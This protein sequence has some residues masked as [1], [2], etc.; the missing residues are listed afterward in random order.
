[1]HFCATNWG[2]EE[3]TDINA[4]AHLSNTTVNRSEVG[5]LDQIVRVVPTR[6]AKPKIITGGGEEGAKHESNQ[7][8]NI[9]LPASHQLRA[10]ITSHH[11]PSNPP[12]SSHHISPPCEGFCRYS[13]SVLEVVCLY[14]LVIFLL[15]LRARYFEG[16]A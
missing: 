7:S 6:G 11:L 10:A 15:K 16:P 1:M 5:H 8:C 9:S 14:C 13:S 4:I 3:Q 2:K 12:A